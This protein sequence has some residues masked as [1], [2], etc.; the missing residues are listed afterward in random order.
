MSLAFFLRLRQFAVLLTLSWFVISYFCYFPI[1]LIVHFD[2][3]VLK[4]N[5]KAI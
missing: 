3:F 4:F 2:N 1:F 5:Q